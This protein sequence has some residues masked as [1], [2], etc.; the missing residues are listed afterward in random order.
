MLFQTPSLTDEDERV[1]AEIETLREDLRHFLR[2]TVRWTKQLRRNLT[3]RNIAGSNTIEGYAASVDDVEALMSGED[4]LEASDETRREVEGYQRAMTYIQG[5]SDA[6]EGFRYDLGLLNG[7][8]F[9]IQ[10]HHPDK[11]PGRLRKGP[12]YITSPDDPMVMDYTG[13][14]YE[15][16]PGLMAELVAWLNEG[17]LDSPVHVRASMAHLNLVKI[18]PWADGNGRTSRALSTLVF[19]REALM[20]SEFSSIEEWLGRGQNTYRYY[21]MLKDVGG[22]VWS[23]QRDAGPWIRFCLG[24]HHMQAQT[25]KRRIEFFRDAW[26]LLVDQMETSG[27]DERMAFALMPALAGGK[28]RRTMYQRDA[29]LSSD[30]AMRDMKAMVRTGWLRSHGQARGRFYTAGPAMDPVKAKMKTITKPLRNPYS[31]R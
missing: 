18:H 22:E 2:P 13:P 7:L 3:A 9:M 15:T 6:G 17:D 14:D 20:P 10:E 5:L 21:D 1:L 30:T 25:A 16:V 23:P 31:T 26:L 27:L 4:P 8:H 28:V 24:A 12:V 19:S 29:D 11:R